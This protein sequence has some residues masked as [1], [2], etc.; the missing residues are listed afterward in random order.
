MGGVAGK[1]ACEHANASLLAS[2]PITPDLA[3]TH[4][5]ASGAFF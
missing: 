2:T 5:L 3:P 1:P 4:V